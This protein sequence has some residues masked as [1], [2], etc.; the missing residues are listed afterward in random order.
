MF[1]KLLVPL[2]GSAFAEQAIGP[3]AA[4]A[5][6]SQ[7]A[8]ELVLVHDPLAFGGLAEVPGEAN[9][10]AA[11]RKYLTT[12][13]RE[14]RDGAS[15]PASHAVLQGAPADR[16]GEQV[17]AVNADLIVMTSHGRTGLSR[18]WLGSIAHGVLRQASIPVLVI[19][20]ADEKVGRLETRHLFKR[21]MVPLDGSALAPEIL[22]AAKALARCNNAT[23]IVLQVV[24]PVPLMTVDV[25]F[26]LMSYPLAPDTEATDGLVDAAKQQLAHVA[27]TLADEGI[28]VETE[29]VVAAH[30]ARA[31]VDWARG[32]RVDAIAM[33]THGR[34]ASRLLL[35][36][37]ADKVL[38]ASDVPM[39]LQR[40]V[41]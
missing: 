6:A 16:I 19:R 29:V 37:V 13:A 32:S 3:A 2:D 27:A 4:I 9:T 24:Q 33:S 41:G 5:R 7:A 17:R 22:P 8:I 31:I 11:E 14:L 34:G 39:L 12:I 38:R 35:G 30:V 20:P 15:V 1:T 10:P 18:A 23:I 25:D 26:S 21:I 40:P 28:A 36:S